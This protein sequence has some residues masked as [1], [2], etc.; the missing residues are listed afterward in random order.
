MLE[1]KAIYQ[2]SKFSSQETRL[3]KYIK[4]IPKEIRAEINKIES[5]YTCG[6]LTKVKKDDSLKTDFKIDKIQER[7][8]KGKKKN[9]TC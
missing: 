9:V 1:R 7:L 4:E 5:K 3:K 2:N 6:K 8:I